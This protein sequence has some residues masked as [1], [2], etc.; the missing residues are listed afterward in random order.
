MVSV[1]A[2][3][4][5]DGTTVRHRADGSGDSPLLVHE[6]GV[7]RLECD[8]DMGDS[9]PKTLR[10]SGTWDDVESERAQG[11]RMCMMMKMGR[12]SVQRRIGENTR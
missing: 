12:I 6:D 9:Y 2:L 8:I 11:K 4:L 5:L 7:L 1:W 3:V 10:G